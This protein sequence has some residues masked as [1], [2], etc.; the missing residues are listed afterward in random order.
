MH[1]FQLHLEQDFY[2]DDIVLLIFYMHFLFIFVQN[3]SEY[4]IFYNNLFLL[5]LNTNLSIK[6]SIF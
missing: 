2:Q 4:L 5:K 6:K 3:F 1:I